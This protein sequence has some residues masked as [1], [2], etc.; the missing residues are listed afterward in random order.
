MDIITA[1]G[2]IAARQDC[3]RSL[4]PEEIEVEAV[5]GLEPYAV[6]ATAAIS[7]SGMLED[8]ATD[9]NLDEAAEHGRTCLNAGIFTLEQLSD[10]AHEVIRQVVEFGDR[11]GIP[12]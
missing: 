12:K 8:A 9:T 5:D 1:H 4:L 2:M 7:L 10:E 6:L 11:V 3:G